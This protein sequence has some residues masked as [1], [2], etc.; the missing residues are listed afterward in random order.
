MKFE[1]LQ[2]KDL[3]T[4]GSAAFGFL[5]LVFASVSYASAAVLIGISVVL[6][7][8]DGK[9]ARLSGKDNGFGRELDSLADAVAFGAAPAFLVFW[10]FRNAEWTLLYAV[11]G[12]VFLAAALVRLARFNLYSAEADFKKD[13]KKAKNPPAKSVYYGLPAPAAA[14]LLVVFGA[15]FGAFA[16]A[17]ELGLAALMLAGF[18]ITKP[19]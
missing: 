12:V 14:L 11:G 2:L 19:F 16:P 3:A 9:L 7:V 17:A 6:D 8:L 1:P 18:K 4:L 10:P 15:F 5:A 13:A